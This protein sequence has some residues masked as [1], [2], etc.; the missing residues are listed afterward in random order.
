MTQQFGKPHAPPRSSLLPRMDRWLLLTLL[1]VVLCGFA[2]MWLGS[3]GFL[4][5]ARLFPYF[6]AAIGIVVTL[7]ALVRVWLGIEPAAGPGQMLPNA[8]EDARAT[9]RMAGLLVCAIAAYFVAIALVGF[10]VATAA[11]ITLFA[12]R[13]G[14]SYVYAIVAAVAALCSVYVLS[15]LFDLYLPPGWIFALLSG[16]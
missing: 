6:I 9:Y 1:S 13:Y 3:R 14:Q 4:P 15:A 7:G 12:R 2:V 10:I 11:F 5:G 16:G 8:D